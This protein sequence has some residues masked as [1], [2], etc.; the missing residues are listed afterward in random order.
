MDLYL[1]LKKIIS[2]AVCLKHIVEIGICLVCH[3]VVTNVNLMS[4][5]DV[6]IQLCKGDDCD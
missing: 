3:W 1:F 5:G 6:Y 4:F 2:I